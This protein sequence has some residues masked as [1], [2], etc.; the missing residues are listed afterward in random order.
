MTAIKHQ[1]VASIGAAIVGIGVG[2]CITTELVADA[3]GALWEGL[4]TRLPIS[5]GQASL[6]VTVVCVIMV[7]LINPRH[8][9][10]GTLLNPLVTSLTTDFIILRIPT[11]DNP[12]VKMILLVIG[13]LLIAIGSGIAAAANRSKEGYIALNLALAE[14]FSGDIAQT[15]FL[16]D[17]ICFVGGMILG[18]KIMI[19]PVIGILMIGFVFKQTLRFCEPIF[20]ATLD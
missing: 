3:L 8:L 7:L 12:V 1:L 15:R 19:G 14:K 9:G 13:I 16:M 10:L 17:L 18:G 5:V 6:V 11:S 2:I 20:Q 4:A